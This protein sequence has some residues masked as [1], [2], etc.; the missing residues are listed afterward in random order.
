MKWYEAFYIID[1]GGMVRRHH[2]EE[3]TYICMAESLNNDDDQYLINE[4]QEYIELTEEELW[5]TD[6]VEY[7]PYVRSDEE[8]NDKE[9]L[10]LVKERCRAKLN[11]QQR[12]LKNHLQMFAEKQKALPVWELGAQQKHF[13]VYS[14]LNGQ[15]RVETTC[16]EYYPNIVYF[17]NKQVCEAAIRTYRPM[18]DIARMLDCQFNLL[19][20]QDYD[21]ETLVKINKMISR[22]KIL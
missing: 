1:C 6:W 22:V 5:A 9:Y 15:Y 18:L 7:D 20:T 14:Y 4:K 11:Y 21:R 3:G 8:L 16:K 13:I 17:S 19:C 10:N 2:W 12:I